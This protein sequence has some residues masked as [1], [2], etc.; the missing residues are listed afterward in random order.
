[1]PESFGRRYDGNGGFS[2]NLHQHENVPRDCG[3]LSRNQAN[4]RICLFE[5]VPTRPCRNKISSQSPAQSQMHESRWNQKSPCQSCVACIRSYTDH[6]TPRTQI[7]KA[8][9]HPPTPIHNKYVR[10]SGQAQSDSNLL[11]HRNTRCFFQSSCPRIAS[12]LQS[13]PLPGV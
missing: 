5:Y 11:K 1:M 8:S 10:Q 2:D 7:P 3:W 6:T 4:S 9:H 12:T 13:V